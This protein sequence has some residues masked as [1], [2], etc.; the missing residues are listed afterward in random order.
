MEKNA[1]ENDAPPPITLPMKRTLDDDRANDQ[2][3]KCP[4][5]HQDDGFWFSLV[6]EL[7]QSIRALLP[8]KCTRMALAFTCQEEY[9]ARRPDDKGYLMA[10]FDEQQQWLIWYEWDAIVR[11]HG[12]VTLSALW[13]WVVRSTVSYADTTNYLFFLV[14]HQPSPGLYSCPQCA[15]TVSFAHHPPLKPTFACTV[16]GCHL[17]P[18]ITCQGCSRTGC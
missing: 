2:T 8:L 12:A 1:S 7:R 5:A 13:H 4:R 3:P 10:C 17:A 15:F 18:M 11:R 9:N 16:D 14:K 6:P